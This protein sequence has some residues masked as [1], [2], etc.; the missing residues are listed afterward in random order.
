MEWKDKSHV[1]KVD[2]SI[3]GQATVICDG[4]ITNMKYMFYACNSLTSIDLS[5]FDTSNVTNMLGMFEFCSLAALDLSNCDTSNVTNMGMMFVDCYNLTT[6]KGVI[7]MKSC[8]NYAGMFSA[9]PKLSGVKI[10]N[11]PAGFD[12]AGLSLSQYTIVS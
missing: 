9:C 11:P 1:I 7:D 6:I 10:K 4:N 2:E 12:G 8:T 3:P 5:N